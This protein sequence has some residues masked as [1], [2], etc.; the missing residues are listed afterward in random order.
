MRLFI[1]QIKE[2]QDIAFEFRADECDLPK[3]IGTVTAPIRFEARVERVKQDIRINGRIAARVQ[4]ACSRCLLPYEERLDEPFEVIYLPGVADEKKSL[5]EI[6]LEEEDLN[7]SYYH[8]E[9]IS[10][11]DLIR[12]Q[13]LLMLPIKPLCRENCKGLCP[14][15]GKDLNEGTCQ[16]SIETG[17]PR[18]SALKKLL[19]T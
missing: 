2:P 14:S 13:L 5:E 6:E 3:D 12:E 11:T 1:E 8:E 18:L 7:V 16:C 9:F 10:V 4:M 19:H 17:D 15:C